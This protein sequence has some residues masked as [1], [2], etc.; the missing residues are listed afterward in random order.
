MKIEVRNLKKVF[1]STKAVNDISFSF[2]S[3]DVMGFVG[4]NGAGKTTTMKIFATLEEPTEGDIFIDGIS[5]T[6]EPEKAREKIGYVP[7][8]L[9]SNKDISVHD[10]L[11]FFARAYGLK[12]QKRKDTISEIEEFTNLTGIKT[13]LID[14]LSKGMKQRVCL[15]RS[16]IHDP[17]LLIMD[18]PAAGLDPRARI[19][20][21]ELLRLL[22]NNGKAILI[23][24]HILSELS[25][26]CTGAIIIE[27]GRLISAGTLQELLTVSNA[28]QKKLQKVMIRPFGKEDILL[29]R[30]I[31]FPCIE[32]TMKVADEIEITVNGG[33]ELLVSLL[34]QL[35]AEDFPILEY[36]KC[37]SD[38]ETVFMNLTR[39]EV[40]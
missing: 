12:G 6:E 36:R 5:I 4:P 27:Q 33:D 34:A 23:S 30:L 22:S 15:A 25:E 37:R 19:E 10:Y 13:K 24:S 1:G 11:D 28:D 2:S 38:L 21:R 31:E 17:G 26:I 16:L 8:S 29:K 40:Q 7:D 32:K 3:G 20:L 14:D 9:P 39:G 35:V 18:E